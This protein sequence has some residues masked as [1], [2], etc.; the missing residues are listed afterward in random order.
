MEVSELERLRPIKVREP[1]YNSERHRF[2]QQRGWIKVDGVLTKTEVKDSLDELKRIQNGELVSSYQPGKSA[3]AY[4]S[5]AKYSRVADKTVDVSRYSDVFYRIATLS[6]IAALIKEVTGLAA[7]RLFGDQLIM[8][9]PA[10]AGGIGSQFHQ[11][12]PFYPIDRCG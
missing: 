7:L 10:A 3:V 9:G 8:K 4:Q 11:D 6:K 2:F 5:T 12:L 1:H